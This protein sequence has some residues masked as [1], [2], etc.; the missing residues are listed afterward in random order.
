MIY[1]EH[2]LRFNTDEVLLKNA[3]TPG[4]GLLQK[5]CEKLNR[6][7]PGVENVTNLA[8]KLDVEVD[9]RRELEGESRGRKRKN[10]TKEVLEWVSIQYPDTTLIDVV[11][12]L[13]RIQRNDAIEVITKEFPETVGKCRQ[14]NTVNSSKAK[15]NGYV[16]KRTQFTSWSV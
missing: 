6:E 8:F 4:S 5:M 3:M 2:L 12:A 14:Q 9:V 16:C 11:K 10:P 7:Q 13:D 1:R 15:I